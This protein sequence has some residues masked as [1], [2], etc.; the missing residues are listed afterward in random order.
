VFSPV[1]HARI[2]C[3]EIK[4][5]N[6]VTFVGRGANKKIALVPEKA[7]VCTICRECYNLCPSGK[8]V[9]ETAV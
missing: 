9:D 5:K 6:A 3:A 4:G 2:S 7:G 8:I 1:S